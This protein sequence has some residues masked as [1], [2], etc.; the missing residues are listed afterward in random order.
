MKYVIVGIC[1]VVAV[2]IVA[3][4][5]YREEETSSRKK[6]NESSPDSNAAMEKKTGELSQSDQ[7]PSKPDIPVEKLP[8]G[9][10]PDDKLVEI[11]DNK[12][13]ARVVA[14]IPD[15]AQTGLA[16][17]NAVQAANAGS[18]ALYRAVIPASANLVDSRTM[19]GAVRGFY[20]G[21]DGGIQGQANFVPKKAQN[22]TVVVANALSAAMSVA[23]MVVGQYY[24]A[25]IDVRLGKI[26]DEISKVADF[27]D[28]EF[29]SRI[30]SLVAHVKNIADFQVEILENDEL[31]LPKI[32]QLDSLEEEC[33]KLLGQTNLTLKGYAGKSDMGYEAYEKEL[34]EAQNWCT[35][36]KVFL[37][38]LYKISELRYALHLGAVS[39]EH[40][41]ALLPTY[42]KQAE[43]ARI[44]LAEWHNATEK[45]LK[46]DTEETRRKR[47]GFDKAFYFIPGLF[48]DD[49]NFK[50][51]DKDTASMIEEQK[52]CL[53]S[54][55]SWDTSDLY[56]EDVQLISKNGKIYYLPTDG[57]GAA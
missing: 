19:E 31:R 45:R 42:A 27:Q 9:A 34:R 57:F 2:A 23:S 20:R 22:G 49:Y 25:Q 35:Y 8:A 15:L 48:D 46:I 54:E 3:L 43:E 38:M 53:P 17:A 56:T 26:S 55:H 44:S 21:V 41:T 47:L 37:D 24:M 50:E 36:Q 5:I 4:L 16:T 14:L 40:C 30:I 52:L 28:N 39:R 1:I 33:T 10:V 32:A 51:I 11:T 12:V 18:E 6:Q 7:N 13:R 29:Q